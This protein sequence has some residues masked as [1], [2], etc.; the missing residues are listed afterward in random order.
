MFHNM[1]LYQTIDHISPS[2]DHISLSL[3]PISGC[4]NTKMMPMIIK[5]IN[6]IITT[7]KHDP[8]PCSINHLLVYRLS[9]RLRFCLHSC[10]PITRLSPS[11]PNC[12]TTVS[13]WGRYLAGTPPVDVRRWLAP[14]L[15]SA[16]ALLL[17]LPMAAGLPCQ[18]A[19]ALQAE[20][21]LRAPAPHPFR[22]P[23][24]E[25]H[26]ERKGTLFQ[27]LGSVGLCQGA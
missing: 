13:L 25:L 16:A 17:C 20:L 27:F 21:A 1:L 19:D 12:Q 10:A 18:F 15:T 14:A 9:R 3:I 23:R 5:M 6:K 7:V 2:I 8:Q 24:A 4:I 22:H 26:V 11:S